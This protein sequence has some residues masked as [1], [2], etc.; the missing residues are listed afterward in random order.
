MDDVFVIIDEESLVLSSLTSSFRPSSCGSAQVA[1]SI[2]WSCMAPPA[3]EE[4]FHADSQP[5]LGEEEEEE[6]EEEFTYPHPCVSLKSLHP[7][8]PVFGVAVSG[9]TL[10]NTHV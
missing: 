1:A 4:A 8:S 7:G 2:S 5:L 10:T 6:E 9:G 3:V